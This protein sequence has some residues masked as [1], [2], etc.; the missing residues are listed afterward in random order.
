VA[1]SPDGKTL[2]SGSVDRTVRLWNASDGT[3]ATPP[4]DLTPQ[5]KMP[6]LDEVRGVA[7]S[8]DGK[9]VAAVDM[10]GALVVWKTADGTNQV[11]QLV[12]PATP[13]PAFGVC[14]NPDGIH[15]QVAVASDDKNAYVFRVPA[16]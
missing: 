4:L 3:A 13:R 9:R 7:F 8:P 14:W 1:F 10:N 12:P 6:P 2:A 15:I 11:W 16:P 5:P